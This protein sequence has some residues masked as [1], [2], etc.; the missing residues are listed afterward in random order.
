[1]R[2]GTGREDQPLK[3]SSNWL[4]LLGVLALWLT[5]RTLTPTAAGAVLRGV[6]LPVCPLRSLTGIPCPFCGITTGCAWIAHGRLGE[7]WHS[8]VLSP[9]LMLGSLVL[10]AY[11]LFVR[12]IARRT[13]EIPPDA[14]LRRALWVVLG[15]ATVASWI[16]NLLRY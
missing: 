12:M 1:M 14:G 4:V 13:L 3:N 16:V 6:R 2:A 7:A 9:F 8:N 11:V 5:A 10:G 15:A